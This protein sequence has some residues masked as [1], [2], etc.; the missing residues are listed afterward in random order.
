MLMR[1][2]L[3]LSLFASSVVLFSARVMLCSRKALSCCARSQR[4]G[5]TCFWVGRFFLRFCAANV[6]LL[7]GNC[8]GGLVV[9]SMWVERALYLLGI[10][11]LRLTS[12]NLVA[13]VLLVLL[14]HISIQSSPSK[15]L[16]RQ[17]LLVAAL[18][19]SLL[20]LLLSSDV[21]LAKPSH[22][23]REFVSAFE[24]ESQ[25]LAY[26]AGSP[27]FVLFVVEAFVRVMLAHIRSILL[28]VF[29]FVFHPSICRLAAS[30]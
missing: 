25:F 21:L 15:P 23:Q 18:L 3:V 16:H 13:F 11:C 27:S 26:F 9:S 17:S 7:L 24:R 14:P 10:T 4:V 30:T 5:R 20:P 2:L 8:S 12:S 1:C 6:L 19:L 28:A 22:V 29:A